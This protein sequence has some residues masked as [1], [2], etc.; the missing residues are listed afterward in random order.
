MNN[1]CENDAFA[2]MKH[3]KCLELTSNEPK[4]ELNSYV[5]RTSTLKSADGDD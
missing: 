3:G 4:A 5:E 2:F 1:G